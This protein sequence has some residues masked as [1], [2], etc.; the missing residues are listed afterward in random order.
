[1]DDDVI[2]YRRLAAAI[3]RRA[4]LDAQSANGQAAAARCWLLTSPWCGDLLDYLSL[5]RRRALAWVDG[6]P[7]LAQPALEL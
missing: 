4:V 1:M 7:D 5:D 3:V 6:L 2:C